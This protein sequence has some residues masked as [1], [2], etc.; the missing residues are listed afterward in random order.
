M[1]PIW[2]FVSNCGLVSPDPGA[3]SWSLPGYPAL[4]DKRLPQLIALADAIREAPTLNRLRQGLVRTVARTNPIYDPN[5]AKEAVAAKAAGLLQLTEKLRGF[6]TPSDIVASWYWQP[7]LHAGVAQILIGRTDEG[8]EHVESALRI[9]HDIEKPDH[10]L[11]QSSFALSRALVHGARRQRANHPLR[12]EQA[13]QPHGRDKNAGGC[14]EHTVRGGVART[15]RAITGEI[16]RG[17]GKVK[18]LVFLFMAFI[19]CTPLSAADNTALAD[20][21]RAGRT[22]AVRAYME[23][24]K[25]DIDAQIWDGM[26]AVIFAIAA[27][28]PDIVRLL[29]DN[30]ADPD[31]FNSTRD[32][33]PLHAAVEVD[34]PAMIDLLID[35][36]AMIDLPNRSGATPLGEA[37]IY[38]RTASIGRLLDRGARCDV[39]SSDGMSTLHWATFL[40][41]PREDVQLEVIKRLLACG[42]DLNA[43]RNGGE[44]VLWPALRE[45]RAQVVQFLISKGS[46]SPTASVGA[47]RYTRPRSTSWVPL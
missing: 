26:P 6:E 21:I 43:K 30:G 15:S 20:D 12:Q 37:L 19:A 14:V 45:K 24:H 27:G 47:L 23:A 31:L 32:F 40:P 22:D 3:Q 11:S 28:K 4:L 2:R 34:N 16:A 18:R 35:R 7:I 36:H 25:A 8:H 5:A 39:S 17:A 33:A 9:V 44:T 38:G 42:A 29:L 10:R 1:P 41:W 13:S 46:A